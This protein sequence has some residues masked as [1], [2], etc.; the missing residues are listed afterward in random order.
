MKKFVKIIAVVTMC[1]IT[2]TMLFGCSG[3]ATLE[4]VQETET[5]T[6]FIP[7]NTEAVELAYV[8]PE[9]PSAGKEIEAYREE[10]KNR[11]ETYTLM[12]ENEIAFLKNSGFILEDYYNYD[13]S[14]LGR[15]GYQEVYSNPIVYQCDNGI[16]VFAINENGE[17]C[18]IMRDT[19][20]V[21]AF[22]EEEGNFYL[23]EIREY[24][25]RDFYGLVHCTAKDGETVIRSWGNGAVSYEHETGIV[26]WWRYGDLIKK[27]EVP[28]NSIYVGYEFNNGYLFKNG[29]DVWAALDENAEIIAHN[30]EFVITAR[31][32]VSDEFYQPLFLM[33]DNTLKTYNRY[34]GD[35]GAPLDD[36]SCL[37]DVQCEGG[38]NVIDVVDYYTLWNGE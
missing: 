32:S 9:A 11:I 37:K 1:L 24:F 2:C 36:V 16:K 17:L 22:N 10:Y 18:S 6:L 27:A 21:F 19:Y 31:Y 28:A 12:T 15:D 5:E 38:Y 26:K 30:V 20:N 7:Q 23:E 34:G 29:T 4:P 13:F 33:T 25:K 8:F 35:Y 3:N 14:I